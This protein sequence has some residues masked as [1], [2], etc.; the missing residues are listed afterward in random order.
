[1]PHDRAEVA[2]DY[3]AGFLRNYHEST[4]TQLPMRAKLSRGVG[5]PQLIY[6]ILSDHKRL[7][8]QVEVNLALERGATLQGGPYFEAE[9]RQWCQAVTEPAPSKEVRLR[10]PKK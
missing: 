7:G 6:R 9:S 3:A 8:L 1:V 2:R 5:M 10:E 4:A